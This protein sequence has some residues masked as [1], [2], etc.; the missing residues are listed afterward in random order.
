MWEEP[1]YSGFRFVP[2]TVLGGKQRRGLSRA[3]I[4]GKNSNPG[5]ER[6]GAFQ[7]GL[8]KDR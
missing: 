6:Y 7:H 5:R 4:D 1:G 3:R 8:G 2:V